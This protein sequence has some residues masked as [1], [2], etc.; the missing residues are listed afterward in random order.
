M[1]TGAST[2]AAAS[3]RGWASAFD[4]SPFRQRFEAKGRFGDYQAA[5]PV[6][7]IIASQ[8]PALLGPPAHWTGDF[9]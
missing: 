4:E 9:S 6:Y 8:S 1:R 3:C 7:V 5:I 2:S